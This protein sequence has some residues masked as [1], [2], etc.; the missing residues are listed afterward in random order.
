MFLH[1]KNS[2]IQT[3]F[4]KK[5]WQSFARLAFWMLIVFVD[6]YFHGNQLFKRMILSKIIG[7]AAYR[8]L[9]TVL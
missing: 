9:Y 5:N 6:I 8:I 2:A 4:F 7:K 3:T 1:A